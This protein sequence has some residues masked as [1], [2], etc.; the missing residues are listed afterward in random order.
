MVSP[1]RELPDVFGDWNSVF[2]RY[3]RWSRKGVCWRIF[4]TM[5]DDSDFEYLIV[6]STV[7][8]AH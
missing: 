5:S 3:S 1:L 8:R 7:V 6:G 4:E 2:Q